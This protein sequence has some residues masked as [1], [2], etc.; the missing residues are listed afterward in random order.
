MALNELNAGGE[1]AW[2]LYISLRFKKEKKKKNY[3]LA[4]VEAT[5]IE[6]VSLEEVYNATTSWVI[7]TRIPKTATE[8]GYSTIFC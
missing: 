1:R 3:Q 8:R 2:L 4:P 7:I 5:T 6:D